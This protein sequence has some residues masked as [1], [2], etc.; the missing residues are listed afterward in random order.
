MSVHYDGRC[1]RPLSSV[2]E[3]RDS[4]VENGALNPI[5][6][7]A[8]MERR[9]TVLSRLS[10]CCPTKRRFC[11]KSAHARPVEG[12]TLRVYSRPAYGRTGAGAG[13][14]GA[15]MA[16]LDRFFD[17]L[18]G[19]NP[20]RPRGAAATH[21]EGERQG[22]AEALAADQKRQRSVPPVPA[23][24]TASEQGTTRLR[25]EDELDSQREAR[26]GASNREV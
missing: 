12:S 22:R 8:G 7:P 26:K 2:T 20:L 16:A 24:Q 5:R 10:Q 23:Q 15:T 21:S 3:G 18:R 6:R 11:M 25:M 14:R 9:A 13:K 4:P 1:G 19:A 17:V